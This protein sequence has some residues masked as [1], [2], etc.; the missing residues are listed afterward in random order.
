MQPWLA[1]GLSICLAFHYPPCCIGLAPDAPSNPSLHCTCSCPAIL[2]IPLHNCIS[3]ALWTITPPFPLPYQPSWPSP[4]HCITVYSENT[5]AFLLLDPPAVLQNN[6]PS[7]LGGHPQRNLN[8]HLPL[9]HC[10]KGAAPRISIP[11]YLWSIDDF[12]SCCQGRK[13]GFTVP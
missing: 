3:L 7:L 2:H 4:A 10:I 12:Y 9:Q 1:S 13:R 6:P 11:G 5:I 8:T